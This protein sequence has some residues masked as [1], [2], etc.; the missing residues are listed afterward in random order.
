MPTYGP[1]GGALQSGALSVVA[2]ALKSVYV[3]RHLA[4]V[5]RMGGRAGAIALGRWLAP[6]GIAATMVDGLCTFAPGT[7]R[8]Y[9]VA[10]GAYPARPY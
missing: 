10:P 6:I 1:N 9:E 8:G 5:L 2:K 4:S 3:S 7:P